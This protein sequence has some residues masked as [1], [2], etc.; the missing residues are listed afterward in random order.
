MKT[1]IREL[2]D[3]A[4]NQMCMEHKAADGPVAWVWEERFAELIIKECIEVISLTPRS[5][6]PKHDSIE[7]IRTHFGLQ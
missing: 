5:N 3:K 6:T 1:K 2:A 7:M 4:Y